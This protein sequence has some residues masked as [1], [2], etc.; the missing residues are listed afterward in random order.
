MTTTICPLIDCAGA[1]RL[2]FSGNENLPKPHLQL[3][4]KARRHVMSS[5]RHM[6]CR[7]SV[8][9]ITRAASK[10]SVTIAASRR[11]ASSDDDQSRPPQA[12]EAEYR[13]CG[14]CYAPIGLI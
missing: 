10:L 4:P 6:P 5:D 7:R 11:R 13:A 9:D 2:G 1:T 8:D 12:V 14:C 3:G